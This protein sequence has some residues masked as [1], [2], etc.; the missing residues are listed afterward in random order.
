MP[1][2]HSNYLITTQSKLALRYNDMSVLE[3]FHACEAFRCM[4]HR[5]CVGHASRQVL[6]TV[7]L[8]T[9]PTHPLCMCCDRC[10]VVS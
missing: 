7:R 9:N 8:P 2:N 1:L 5:S 4:R 10:H 6:K 3:N